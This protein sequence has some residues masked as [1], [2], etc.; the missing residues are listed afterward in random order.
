VFIPSP[1][2]G[3]ACEKLAEATAPRRI[4]QR[5]KIQAARF[6]ELLEYLQQ[7]FDVLRGLQ[8]EYGDGLNVIGNRCGVSRQRI[9]F[10]KSFHSRKNLWRHD[11]ESGF[12]DVPFYLV[13]AHPG[14]YSG[15]A[16]RDE[17]KTFRP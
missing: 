7:D 1:T 11:L 2:R 5:R 17:S 15:A 4:V 3:F 8:S 12:N 9:S 13:I 14:H 16:A 10:R 6:G